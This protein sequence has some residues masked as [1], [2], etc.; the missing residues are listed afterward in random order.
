MVHAELSGGR[1]GEFLQ[2]QLPV[3]H[4]VETLSLDEA[5]PDE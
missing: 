2:G 1:P 3:P 4:M 5:Q